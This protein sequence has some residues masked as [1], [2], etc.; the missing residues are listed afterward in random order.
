M[1]MHIESDGTRHHINTD[2]IVGLSRS[3]RTTKIHCKYGHDYLIEDYNGYWY[4]QILNYMRTRYGETPKL[5]LKG[6]EEIDAFE[7]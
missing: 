3:K 4:N 1:L 6:I 7:R 2:E 5:S